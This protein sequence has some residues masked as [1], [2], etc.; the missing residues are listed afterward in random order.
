MSKNEK[1]II[2]KYVFLS[3]GEL[4]LIVVASIFAGGL[5]HEQLGPT[6]PGFEYQRGKIFK[7]CYKKE[8]RVAIARCLDKAWDSA[9]NVD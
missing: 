7:A 6:V 8:T 3:R 1:E 4:I 2:S 5:L 9:A